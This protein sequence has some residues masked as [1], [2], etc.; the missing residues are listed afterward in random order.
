MAAGAGVNSYIHINYRSCYSFMNRLTI[1][2][3]E[4]MLFGGLETELKKFMI[5][6]ELKK[7]MIPTESKKTTKSIRSKDPKIY[8]IHKTQNIHRF[9]ICKK[10]KK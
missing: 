1:G 3:Q 2:Y 6:T 4:P 10:L 8:K 9:A 5:P 7:F